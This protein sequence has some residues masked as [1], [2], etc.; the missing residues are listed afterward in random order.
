MLIDDGLKSRP[1]RVNLMNPS[2]RRFS[3]ASGEH[4]T[5]KKMVVCNYAEYYAK[6]EEQTKLAGLVAEFMKEKVKFEP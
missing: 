6:Q 5:F 3:A 2:F 1:N 4:V